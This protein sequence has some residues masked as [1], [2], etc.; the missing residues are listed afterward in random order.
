MQRAQGCTPPLVKVGVC[1]N[2]N[3]ACGGFTPLP[4]SPFSS[5]PGPCA[6]L[7]QGVGQCLPRR[8]HSTHACAHIRVG[9]APLS[10]H[11][12]CACVQLTGTLVAPREDWGTNP[13]ELIS[14]ALRCSLRRL[15][16]QRNNLVSSNPLSAR[17][18]NEHMHKM[19][20]WTRAGSD[21]CA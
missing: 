13:V 18:C 16:L 4:S 10:H 9:S 7:E 3:V 11:Y 21:A 8:A 2:N 19:W 1:G 15:Q 5:R 14:S 6:M 17:S 20:Y 12:A